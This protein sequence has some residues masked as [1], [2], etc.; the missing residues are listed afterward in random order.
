MNLV[1]SF[2]S[3]FGDLLSSIPTFQLYTYKVSQYPFPDCIFSLN[4]LKTLARETDG[5]YLFKLSFY[6]RLVLSG[7][8]ILFL[9]FSVLYCM[10]L[11]TDHRMTFEQILTTFRVSAI[12]AQ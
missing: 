9:N 11:I 7:A 8:S 6:Q 3:F 4:I 12:E 5:Q 1:V 10:C 2:S